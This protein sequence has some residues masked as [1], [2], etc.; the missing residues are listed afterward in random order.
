[1]LDQLTQLQAQHFRSCVKAN[2]V[3]TRGQ[4]TVISEKHLGNGGFGKGRPQPFSWY[5]GMKA[6]RHHSDNGSKTQSNKSMDVAVRNSRPEVL[7]L[8]LVL[9]HNLSKV[10]GKIMLKKIS[11]SKLLTMAEF[12]VWLQQ[13]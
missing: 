3:M 2:K 8:I 5:P 4:K 11:H 9:G 10:G 12:E 1:M 13:L 6:H 7:A